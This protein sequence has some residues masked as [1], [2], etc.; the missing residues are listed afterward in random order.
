MCES[1]EKTARFSN[2]KPPMKRV[3]SISLINKNI[4]LKFVTEVDM[5]TR[6]DKYCQMSMLCLTKTFFPSYKQRG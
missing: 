3:V 2:I 1:F 4:A 5:Q 6:A